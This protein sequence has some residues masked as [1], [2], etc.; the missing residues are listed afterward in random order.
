MWHPC[1]RDSWF[2]PGTIDPGAFD[3]GERFDPGKIDPG[4]NG[5]EVFA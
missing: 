3:P 1:T 5:G 2:D 4:T